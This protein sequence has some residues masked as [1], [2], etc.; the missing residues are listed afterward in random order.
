MINGSAAANVVTTGTF[1]IPLMKSVGYK[2]H[3]AGAVEAAAST[4]G[5]ILPPVMGAAAF[6][7]AEFLGIPYIKVAAAAAIPGVLYFFSVWMMVH[8]EALK[9]GLKGIPRNRLPKVW[10]VLKEG[11]HLLIPVAL[12]IYLLIARYTPIYAAFQSIIAAI[13]VSAFR[14]ST[15][16]NL[17][18]ALKALENGARGILTVAIACAAVGFVV[19]VFSLTG[20]GLR[21][22]D[23]IVM[24]SHDS[25]ILTLVLSMVA[26]II[27]GMGMPTT[28]AYIIT[29]TVAVPAL[30]A[31]KVP[32]I[33]G[34]LF[35]LYFASLSAVTPPVALA[36]YAGAGLAGANPSKVGWTAVRLALAGFI[37]PFMFIFSPPL[38]LMESSVMWTIWGVITASIGIVSLGCSLEGFMFGRTIWIERIL[39]FVAALLLIKS[40]LSTDIPGLV[41]LFGVALHQWTRYRLHAK[42]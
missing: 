5:Q 11:G 16:L 9:Q 17:S 23:V 31:F 15:R 27:L 10:T 25:L 37:I 4:G 1:T 2:A 42:A 12:L 13:V 32:P 3:F 26:C 38:I 41:I 8:L 20:L 7:M 40:G 34:H 21:L 24:L 33:A 28:A 14:K 35:A 6:V 29:A 39:L 19:G 36:A 30:D 18:K 22:A